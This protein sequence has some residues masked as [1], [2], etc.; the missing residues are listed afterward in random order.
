ML[1]KASANKVGIGQRGQW[2]RMRT[3]APMQKSSFYRTGLFIFW[4]VLHS[5]VFVCSLILFLSTTTTPVD[6][7]WRQ[8]E[9]TFWPR[10][11][12][13]PSHPGMRHRSDWS[14]PRI[15][16]IS[17]LTQVCSLSPESRNEDL[18]W[19]RE[20]EAFRKDTMGIHSN[21]YVRA[22]AKHSDCLAKKF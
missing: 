21:R 11:S 22:R 8:S 2:G 13:M 4:I 19:I 1:C 15:Y 3:S 18:S 7:P 10:G 14:G 6:R 20:K 5:S 17:V 9:G 16:T 12:F